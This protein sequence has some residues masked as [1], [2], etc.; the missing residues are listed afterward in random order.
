[1]FDDLKS[2]AAWFAHWLDHDALPLWWRAGADRAGGGYYDALSLD[3]APLDQLPRRARVQARQ[4]F[5]YATLGPAGW[6]GPWRDAA[7]QGLDALAAHHRRD[8]GLYA[9]LAGPDG[10]IIDPA[11]PLY[12][13][14][15]VLLALAA[16][17]AAGLGEGRLATEALRLREALDAYRHP[18]GGFRELGE[19][20]FQ[21]N[22]Q[23]HLLEAVL[24]WDETGEAGWGALADELAG[25]C[26]DRFIDPDGGFLREFFD[27]DWAARAGDNG[28]L[29][30]P[31]HQFEWA[32]LLDRWGARRGD[33]R[34]M[35]AARRLYAA[36][37]RGV[38]AGRGVAV[39]ALWDDLSVREAEARLW[40]QTEHLRSAL[41]IGD[42]AQALV[43]ARGL[44]RYLQTPVQGVWRDKLK[45]DG[46]FVEEPAPASS[47]YHIVGA[48]MAL[49]QAV[50][51]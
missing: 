36:G 27:A 6:D 1:M 39:N 32:W 2:A 22:A 5:V 44:A 19:Q 50:S 31:G 12:E 21:A 37:L 11:A 38:D 49:R 34:A 26:L 35:S 30:E 14:A 46:S 8:D 42:E 41:V 18:A 25:L 43:A 17:H 51:P 4:A 33:A 28:R 20:P 13:Q 3:G 10:E 9:C 16:G 15:F 7:W 48:C 23:M 45:A 47:L 24:L 40:P 29:V